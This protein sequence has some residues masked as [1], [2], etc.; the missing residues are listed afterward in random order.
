MKHKKFLGIIGGEF[1]EDIELRVCHSLHRR[2]VR[3][4]NQYL[5]MY[6]LL[7]P[8]Q[9]YQPTIGAVHLHSVGTNHE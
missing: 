6:I 7:K 2:E 1:K 3:T 5:I 4:N 8:K 9:V